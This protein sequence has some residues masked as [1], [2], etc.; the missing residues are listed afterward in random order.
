MDIRRFFR[1]LKPN[2]VE[3]I[4]VPGYLKQR[5][6]LNP[7]AFLALSEFHTRNFYTDEQDLR[8]YKGYFVFAVDGSKVNVPNTEENLALYGGQKN[9]FGQQCQVGVSCLYDVFNKMILDCTVSPYKFSE[10][11]QV[12][13]HVDKITSI[14]GDHKFLVVL[15]RGYPSSKLFI[16]SLEQNQK[17]VVRL[18]SSDFRR[19]Q[20]SMISDDED[21]EIVFSQ[22]RVNYYR[23]T[24]FAQRL[25]AKGSISLRF[26]KVRL[27]NDVIEVL[28]TNL[29]RD[30]F[31]GDD[32]K[33]IYGAR[34]GI[35]TAYDILKNKFLL[36][37]Y[38]GKK[39]IIVEQDI[40][41]AIY[42]YNIAQDMI[43]D[44]D[45]EQQQKNKHKNYKHQMAININVSIGILKED[46]I[47]MALEHNSENREQIFNDIIASMAS[48]IVPV[49][50]GRQFER[51]KKYPAIKYPTTRKRSY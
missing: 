39:A 3:G 41:A 19:E 1:F 23:G 42:L 24:A 32:L 28:A 45:M 38:T 36:E 27:P 35:E 29:S 48:H 51:K 34:W 33:D 13:I 16:D 50:P 5:L 14:I 15:D 49:R 20:M 26:V 17:F 47:R 37:N 6:K 8:R 31:E 46:L 43:R 11:E 10:R 2:I 30:E 40:F 4:S 22:E 12:E 21:V 9:Q 25:R 18:S 7:R 44:A